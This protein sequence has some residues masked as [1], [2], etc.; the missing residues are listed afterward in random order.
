MCVLFSL[1]FVFFFSSLGTLALHGRD[2]GLSAG[3]ATGEPWCR[4][5]GWSAENTGL[6]ADQEVTLCGKKKQTFSPRLDIFLFSRS[7][8][9]PNENFMD[10][11]EKLWLTG[12][13]ANVL[14]P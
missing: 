4:G 12:F 6:C 13:F 9:Q 5:P 3:P 8:A 11:L 7:M 1:S 2:F 10:Q 14:T